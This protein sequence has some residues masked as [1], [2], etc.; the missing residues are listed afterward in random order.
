ML[1]GAH[2]MATDAVYGIMSLEARLHA[3]TVPTLVVSEA[4]ALAACPMLTF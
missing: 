1:I 2:D 3:I 4:E